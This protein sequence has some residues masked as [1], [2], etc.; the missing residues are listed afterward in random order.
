M[1]AIWDRV[2]MPHNEPTSNPQTTIRR[3]FFMLRIL[4]FRER[5]FEKHRG[6]DLHASPYPCHSPGHPC[7]TVIGYARFC[8]TGHFFFSFSL[9]V[10]EDSTLKGE[11]NCQPVP[12]VT[13][14]GRIV[15]N[16]LV[17]DRNTELVITYMA[18]WAHQFF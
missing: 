17:R 16:E 5:I 18:F 3:V 6:R 2:E 1:R 10:D 8:K 9:P 15:P 13:L 11:F 14:S 7:P 12:S 4:L